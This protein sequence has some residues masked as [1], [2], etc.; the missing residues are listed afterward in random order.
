ML[1]DPAPPFWPTQLGDFPIAACRQGHG[2]RIAR[3]DIHPTF[4]IH[5]PGQ[6]LTLLRSVAER[7]AHGVDIDAT[8]RIREC[9]RFLAFQFGLHGVPLETIF[10]EPHGSC[11]LSGF[12]RSA[13]AR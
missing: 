12:A 8:R 5:E 6:L 9:V 2:W 7:G 13:A 10:I 4:L 3:R 11:S 1:V